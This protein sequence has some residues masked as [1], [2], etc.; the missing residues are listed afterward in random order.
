MLQHAGGCEGTRLSL[1]NAHPQTSPWSSVPITGPILGL[2]QHGIAIK[3]HSDLLLQN[4]LS[5][6]AGAG[7]KCK[8]LLRSTMLRLTPQ[9]FN[10]NLD[11]R[12]LYPATPPKHPSWCKLTQ[13]QAMTS[14]HWKVPPTGHTCS[15]R[16]IEERG[17][18]LSCE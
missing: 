5:H 7:P 18:P 9:T 15:F 3:E 8:S 1:S 12:P 17:Y 13:T 2:L 11:T 16:S 14:N 6:S 10:P 4:S